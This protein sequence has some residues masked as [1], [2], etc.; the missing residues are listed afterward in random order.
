MDFRYERRH[1][2]LGLTPD[3]IGHELKNRENFFKRLDR[4]V[5][6]DSRR[7]TR[8]RLRLA[9]GLRD[10]YIDGNPRIEIEHQMLRR[11]PLRR[12]R[13][14]LRNGCCAWAEAAI[15]GSEHAVTP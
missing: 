8:K 14:R 9:L 2:F 12:R 11:F 15:V 4:Y 7:V 1:F 3:L 6:P 5:L 13:L 10:V